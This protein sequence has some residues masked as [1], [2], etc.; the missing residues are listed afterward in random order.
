MQEMN[1]NSYDA[2][3]KYET[4]LKIQLLTISEA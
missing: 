3:I 1:C 2:D 4:L